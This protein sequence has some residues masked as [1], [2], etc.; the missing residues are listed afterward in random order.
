MGKLITFLIVI[1]SFVAGFLLSNELAKKS[2]LKEIENAQIQNTI[3]SM[4]ET[5]EAAKT[6]K[7]LEEVRNSKDKETYQNLSC[8]LLK[9]KQPIILQLLKSR[10][11]SKGKKEEINSMLKYINE[12]KEKNICDITKL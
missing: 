5:F 4:F 1:V 6:I 3:V 11:L 9:S 10:E 7:Y 2:E 12:I 8:V